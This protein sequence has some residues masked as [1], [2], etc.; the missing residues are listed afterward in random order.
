MLPVLSEVAEPIPDL[1]TFWSSLYIALQEWG[2]ENY[3][4]LK[5]PGMCAL[6]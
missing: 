1:H 2:E 6:F 4:F 3:T 5:I